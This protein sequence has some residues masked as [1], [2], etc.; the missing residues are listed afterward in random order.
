MAARDEFT[1]DWILQKGVPIVKDYNREGL[2][3]TLRAL[4]YR[5]VS[6]GMTNTTRHYKRVIAAMTYARWA[7]MVNFWEFKDHDRETI[8]STDYEETNVENRVSTSM[9][10]INH[11]ISPRSYN[12]NKWENQ[13]N[14]VEIFIE[15]KALQ[16]VFNKP[17]DNRGVALNPCKGYP[18]LTYLNDA[19]D[20]FDEAISEGK[21][22]IILYFGDYDPSGED[23]PRSLKANLSRMGTEVEVKRIALM[24]EQVLAWKLP[25]APAKPTDSRTAN[26][27]G[28]GQVELDAVEPRK[29]VKLV[30]KAIDKVFDNKIYEALCETEAEERKTFVIRMKEEIDE[31]FNSKD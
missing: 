26:W 11:Y 18:S 17:C 16:G 27:G 3:L 22:P 23:I 31:R 21:N 7:G 29:L 28:L 8:G 24:E 14:Y 13:P 19:S 20:R 30:D 1:R 6:A 5:L 15:K 12:K 9:N 25:P 4:H 10:M 2:D